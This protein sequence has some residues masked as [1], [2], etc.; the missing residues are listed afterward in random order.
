MT[1]N[2][3]P[4]TSRQFIQ[5]LEQVDPTMP[6]YDPIEEQRADMLASGYATRRAATMAY[7][8]KPAPEDKLLYVEDL[9]MVIRES[10]VTE[11]EPAVQREVA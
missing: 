4:R 11:L 1:E 5:E 10:R 7:I 8:H 6:V 3:T 2:Y 9:G